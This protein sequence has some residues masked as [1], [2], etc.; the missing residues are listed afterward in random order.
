[1]AKTAFKNREEAIEY[2]NT[3]PLGSIINL[4]ADLLI[5][6]QTVKKIT[7][8]QEQFNTMFKIVGIREDGSAEN[9]GRNKKSEE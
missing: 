2:L 6:R 9:R 5:D 4:C 7:I 8:T 3:L 1:M